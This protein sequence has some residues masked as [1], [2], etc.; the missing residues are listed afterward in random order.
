LLK[1][2]QHAV[3]VQ[4]F[5]KVFAA[6]AGLWLETCSHPWLLTPFILMAAVI[7]HCQTAF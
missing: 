4:Q 6:S 1:Q 2:A 7:G 5:A 3:A